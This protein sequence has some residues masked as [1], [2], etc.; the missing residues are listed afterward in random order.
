MRLMRAFGVCFSE[1]LLFGCLRLSRAKT[2]R[3]LFEIAIF[4]CHKFISP[5]G[6]IK[7]CL[8]VF[9][10]FVLFLHLM[11]AIRVLIKSLDFFLNFEILVS[12]YSK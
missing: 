1:Y 5:D 2:S 6:Q 10:C 11:T 9:V 3:H 12:S 7:L 8:G 4:F